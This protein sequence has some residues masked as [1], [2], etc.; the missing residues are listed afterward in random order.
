M[1][2]RRL[3]AEDATDMRTIP[4]LLREKHDTPDRDTSLAIFI[5]YDN[6]LYHHRTS[7]IL[8]T[9]TKALSQVPFDSATSRAKCDVRI[10]GGWYEGSAITRLAQDIAIELEKD[11][12][13]IIRIPTLEGRHLPI[14]TNAELAVALLEEPGHH[15]FNTY[16]RKSKPA[17]VRVETP[18]IVGCTDPDCLLPLVKKL[19]K[20]GRCQKPGCTVTP[21]NLV[22]RHEQKI[23]DAMLTC[24]LI[25]AASMAYDYL[26]L[27]SGDDDFVPAIRTTLL[28]GAVVIRL[29]PK[30]NGQRAQFPPLSNRLFE[31]D[32]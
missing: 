30:P 29:H 32:L 23:V 17:N 27:V 31:L 13:A 26:V 10:Y 1:Q 2:Y 20:T 22:Y 14:P 3:Q 28:R 4:L 9:V 7:G 6:L 11:F 15:L 19:L 25:R 8:C 12:P 18:T 24:D 16:R 21:E 5:D